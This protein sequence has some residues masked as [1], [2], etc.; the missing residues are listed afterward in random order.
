MRACLVASYPPMHCGIAT[1]TR[2]LRDGLLAAERPASVSIA[3]IG[4]LTPGQRF[5]REVVTRIDKED[6]PGYRRVGRTLNRA[7]FDV[8][9]VQH[10]FGIFG[11]P[12]G[13]AVVDLLSEVRCPTVTTL[14]TVLREPP[15]PYRTALLEVASA[16]DHLVVPTEA[17]RGILA[18]VYAVDPRLVSVIHHGVPDVPFGDPA[19]AKR[20]L[21]FE[22]RKVLLTFG[23]LSANKGIEFA[24]DALPAVVEAHP[25]VLYVVLG[26]THP[27]VRRHDGEEYRESLERR[28]KELDLT[29]HV[30]F[31]DRYVEQ[32]EL[33][34][35]LSACDVYVTPYLSREQIVSGT[36]AYAVGMGKAVV[37]TPYVYAEELLADGRGCLVGFGDSEAMA[38][39]LRALLDD[40][41]E[42]ERIRRRAYSFGR[43][44]TW[45]QVGN[46]Y[47]E[48]FDRLR[49]TADT[50]SGCAER[51]EPALPPVNF[52]HLTRL[53]DDTGT[54]QH[55]LD[56]IPDRRFGYTTDD[57]ARAL[58][59][60][61]RRHARR[62]DPEARR[63]AVTSLAFLAHAQRDDG[64]FRDFL[65]YDRRWLDEVG[66]EDTLGQSLWGL[67]VARAE[68]VDDDVRAVAEGL[69]TRALPHAAE[70]VY[71][72]ALAYATCGLCA[73]LQA[74][75]GSRPARLALEAATT[76][77]LDEYERN[78]AADWRFPSAELTYANAK[79]PHA[80]L[81][82]S[83]V[84]SRPR[85]R[86]VGLDCLDF[87]VAETFDDGRFDFVGNQGWHRQG[88][89]R[90]TFG[91]QP[92]EAGYMIEACL[93]A[94]ALT[95]QRRYRDLACAAVGWLTGRNRLGV[96]LYDPATGG[97]CDGIDR[98]GP[99]H[100]S[101][102]ESVICCL[103][104]LLEAEQAGLGD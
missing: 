104:G 59:V 35:Y 8:V 37:S 39:A 79:L 4:E 6:L 97:C 101:G 12:E 61:V 57:A 38:G 34:E 65:G 103:L 46:R 25:D 11:G 80:L 24:L 64:R 53:T 67:G 96:A 47:L 15:E 21:G 44:M 43:Q 70:L 23:L 84:L 86:E 29:D 33:V 51:G 62:G 82:A 100:N 40:E 20:A 95:G 1:F 94:A 83:R 45:E 16:S 52:A 68:A 18:D 55:A 17:A 72:R 56:E 50:C 30:Q 22:G 99:N 42:R 41:Q 69:F 87:L 93:L 98:D 89:P 13:R 14:H 10:E 5:D 3:A 74:R 2:D 76:R 90:A 91:Q 28:V 60:G 9:C 88:G 102:A 31:H 92:I 77:L 85:L 19:P 27:E 54:I 75:P 73:Y 71:P 63:I 66:G 49:S 26:A 7:G 32:D 81:L 58:I 78:L 36:L 48:L